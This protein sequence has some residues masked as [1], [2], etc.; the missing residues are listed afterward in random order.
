MT[1]THNQTTVQ[2]APQRMTLE[3]YL[4]YDDGTETRYELVDGI[5]VEMPTESPLNNTIALFL[6]IYFA[7]QLG[8]SHYRFA[9]HHQIQVS[10]QKVTAR[11]PDLIMHSEASAAAILHDGQL[12]RI[13]QP[14]PTLVVEVVSSSDTDKTSRNRDYVDKR[15]EYAQRGIP[16]YW[17]IDPIANVV[18]VLTLVGQQYQEQRFVGDEHL[19]SQGFPQLNLSAVQV[20]TA[21]L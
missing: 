21:G 13:D 4:N 10:S 11:E 19:V 15:R 5:L 14:A 7:S 12:L 2:P 6:V 1:I 18:L 20:L 16:E 17:I 8:I 9:T 3:E